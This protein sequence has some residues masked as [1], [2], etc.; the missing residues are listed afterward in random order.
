MLVRL[1]LERDGYQ[2]IEGVDGTEAVAVALR[3]RPDLVI[4]DLMMPKMDGYEAIQGIRRD[5]SLATVPIM[6]LTA[7]DGADIER[8]VLAMGADDYMVKPFE[9]EV[10][11]SRVRAAF[12][13]LDH[14][15]AA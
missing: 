6:V 12:G 14:T 11:L 15:A 5:L 4:I 9:P 2:V 10:L 7:E 13:R 3:E 8:R 1:L